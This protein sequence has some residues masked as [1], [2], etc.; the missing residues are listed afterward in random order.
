MAGKKALLRSILHATAII[1]RLSKSKKQDTLSHTKHLHALCTLLGAVLRKQ[2]MGK[3]NV[4]R[5]GARS[6]DTPYYRVRARD[7]MQP[8]RLNGIRSRRRSKQ[9]RTAPILSPQL[10]RRTDTAELQPSSQS[11]TEQGRQH[12]SPVHHNSLEIDGS[13]ESVPGRRSEGPRGVRGG[14]RQRLLWMLR[15]MTAISATFGYIGK[16]SM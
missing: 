5:C 7:K 8:K 11:N 10:R 2:Q 9:S 6:R 13:T 15:T 14:S 16:R 3:L 12:A 4:A 1:K